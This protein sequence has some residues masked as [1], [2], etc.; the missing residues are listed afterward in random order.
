MRSRQHRV[1][2]TDDDLAAIEYQCQISSP[3]CGMG[4]S[5]AFAHA[6]CDVG[7]PQGGVAKCQAGAADA[8]SGGEKVGHLN[9]SIFEKTQTSAIHPLSTAH[10]ESGPHPSELTCTIGVEKLFPSIA[11]ML[12]SKLF[13]GAYNGHTQ[14]TLSL[15][16]LRV[17]VATTPPSPFSAIPPPGVRDGGKS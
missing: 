9:N 12:P 7:T 6:K 17:L 8:V 15:A 16:P 2:T 11:A 1:A 4:F 13:C 3:L 5:V 14:L 10:L